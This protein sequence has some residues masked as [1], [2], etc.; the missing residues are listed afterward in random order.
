MKT[1][2]ASNIRTRLSWIKN[3]SIAIFTIVSIVILFADYLFPLTAIQRQYV[4]TFDFFVVIIWH[5][6][7]RIG[8]T[9]RHEKGGS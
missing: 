7:N 9:M 4:Y 1:S 6:I 8:S 2:E 3:I 5:S